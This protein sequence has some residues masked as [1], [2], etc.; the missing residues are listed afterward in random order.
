MTEGLAISDLVLMFRSKA[1]LRPDQGVY[2]YYGNKLFRSNELVE[3]LEPKEGDT[4]Q[5]QAAV[6]S[7]FG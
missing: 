3:R 1:N 7:S 2:M 5:L 4:V 6:I